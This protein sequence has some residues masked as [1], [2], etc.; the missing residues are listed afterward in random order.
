MYRPQDLSATSLAFLPVAPARSPP[1]RRNCENC[2]SLRI[3]LENSHFKVKKSFD[4]G[5]GIGYSS[6]VAVAN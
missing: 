1:P 5:L 2:A 3:G 4:T 6:E